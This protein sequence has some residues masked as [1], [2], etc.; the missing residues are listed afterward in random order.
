MSYNIEN[1][2]ADYQELRESTGAGLEA[3]NIIAPIRNFFDGIK[4]FFSDRAY[5]TAQDLITADLSPLSKALASHNY[6]DFMDRMIYQP[7]RLNVSYQEW[8][9]NLA[10]ARAFCTMLEST[11]ISKLHSWLAGVSAGNASVAYAPNVDKAILGKV[12]AMLGKSL[13]GK[14]VTD[15]SFAARFPNLTEF[16]NVYTDFNKLV[17]M[18]KRGQIYNFNLA[19][20]RV[21]ELS[22]L[23][24]SQIESGELV[25]SKADIDNLAKTLLSTARA[26]DLYSVCHTLFIST[27]TALNNTAVKLAK[28][29]K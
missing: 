8:V 18:L 17:A 12:E 6:T 16:T 28:E 22:D 7:A 3:L 27:G 11:H 14:D 24:F 13:G 9:E 29:V 5:G 26:A 19:V 20:K 10:T 25:L 1:L 2:E 23:V 21:A 4:K 15:I